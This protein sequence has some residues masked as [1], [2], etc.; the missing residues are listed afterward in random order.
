MYEKSKYTHKLV[1]I[2]MERGIFELWLHKAVQSA[3]AKAIC[4][5]TENSPAFRVNIDLIDGFYFLHHIDSAIPQ[6]FDKVAELI[7]RISTIHMFHQ[8]F[9]TSIKDMERSNQAEIDRRYTLLGAS[10]IRPV[11][12]YKSL[13]NNKWKEVWIDVLLQY[14]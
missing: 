1:L 4:C 5:P 7:F 6:T 12:F 8:Y 3:L 13:K 2:A 10:R 11:D 14:W 9:I